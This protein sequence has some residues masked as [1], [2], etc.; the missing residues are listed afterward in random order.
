MHYAQLL[1][2]RKFSMLDIEHQVSDFVN[3]VNIFIDFI[4][5]VNCIINVT[6]QIRT[7]TH[8]YIHV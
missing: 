3:S 2:G 1:F 7:H 6:F 4:S 8:T 5:F